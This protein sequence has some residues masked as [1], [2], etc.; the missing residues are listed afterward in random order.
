ML[1]AIF[2]RLALSAILITSVVAGSVSA[3]EITK[4][5]T[6]SRPSKIGSQPLTKGNYTIKFAED[7][8]GQLAIMKG[9]HELAEVPYKL[10]KLARPSMD[11]A[12]VFAV[13]S[14]GSYQVKRI[15]LK[16]SLSAIEIE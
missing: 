7:K 16:G 11:T 15:E 2:K 14:D 12:V 10:V 6:I 5:L 4:E 8:D 3:Q 1:R 9:S 13:T